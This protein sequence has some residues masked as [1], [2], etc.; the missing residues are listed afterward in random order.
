MGRLGKLASESRGLIED[1]REWVDLRMQLV[2]VDVEERIQ[3]VANQ[4]AAMLVVL[5]FGL[6]TALFLLHG[7]SVLIG[8]AL[9]NEAWG[10]LIVAAFLGVMTLA[11]HLVKPTLITRSNKESLGEEKQSTESLSPGNE[12]KQ[13]TPGGDA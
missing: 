3:A 11:V 2:Q 1:L 9:G 7:V 6:F 12:P 10:Y 4:M 5:V 13:L 8:T